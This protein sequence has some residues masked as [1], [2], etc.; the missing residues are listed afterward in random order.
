[1]KKRKPAKPITRPGRQAARAMVLKDRPGLLPQA[2]VTRKYAD[3]PMVPAREVPVE[4]SPQ[5]AKVAPWPAIDRYPVILGS[6]VTISY[7][8]SVMRTC[9]TGYRREYCDLL[10][11]LLERDPHTYAVSAQR[12]HAVSGGELQITAAECEEKDEERAEEIRAYVDRRIKAIPDR[13]QALSQLQWGGL[14]YGVGASEISWGQDQDGYYPA[15]LHWIHSRRLNYPDPGSW[16]VRIWDQGGVYSQSVTPGGMQ[17]APTSDMFGVRADALPG[18]FIV[19]APAVRGNYPTRDGL[20]R[21]VCFWSA[22]KLMA[23]R[24]GAQYIERFG[25]PWVI[26]YYKTGEKENEH[27]TA[28]D[29]DIRDAEESAKALGLGSL[30]SATL[31]DSTKVDIFG[32]AA[33][34]PGRQLFHKQFIDLCNSEISKAVLGQTDTTEPSPNGSRGAVEVRKQG[35]QELYRYDAACL[36]DTLQND[37]VKVIVELNFPGEMHLCPQVKLHAAEEP[38]LNAILERA[39]KMAEY[40]APVDA[41]ALAEEIG[42]PLAPKPDPQDIL[43]AQLEAD[44]LADQQAELDHNNAQEMAKQQHAQAIET[45][46]ATDDA[47]SK[48]AKAAGVAHVPQPPP[49]APIETP[50]QKPLRPERKLPKDTT[51][52]LL[53]IA[54]MKPYELQDLMKLQRGE[55]LALPPKPIAPSAEVAGPAAAQAAMPPK[56]PPGAPKPPPFGGASK[57]PVTHGP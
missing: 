45:H 46:K 43:D 2:N 29:D 7:I 27:R 23:A 33:N 25:K 56:A 35:T 15:R 11:E 57:G 22:L 16:S 13:Q 31:P 4:P 52:T 6:R 37:L 47:N 41:D 20:G 21:Q 40:G 53:H 12:V 38:D 10:D 14:Y 19:H 24:G 39:V 44:K 54:P 55:E 1:M 42:V 3:M 49:S 50:F 30:S 8:S 32:P 48:A 5:G 26:A 51:R 18:K 34:A 36:A 9:L 17:D 28:D